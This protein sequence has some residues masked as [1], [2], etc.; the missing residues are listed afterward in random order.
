MLYVVFDEMLPE[1]RRSGHGE[2]AVTLAIVGFAIMTALDA[3]LS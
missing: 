1:T 2:L 3:F